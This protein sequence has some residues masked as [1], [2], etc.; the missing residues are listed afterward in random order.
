MAARFHDDEAK[1]SFDGSNHHHHTRNEA[2]RH[3]QQGCV[4]LSEMEEVASHTGRGTHTLLLHFDSFWKACAAARVNCDGWRIVIPS[5]EEFLQIVVNHRCF[6]FATFTVFPFLRTMVMPIIRFLPFPIA[7]ALIH[8]SRCPSR[9][10]RCR[11]HRCP[12]LAGSGN[13]DHRCEQRAVPRC[14]VRCCSPRP[15]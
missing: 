3:A 14:A 15:R 4:S 8:A 7:T 5:G 1:A 11:G 13:R 6:Y 9:C 12:V 10:C 2:Q